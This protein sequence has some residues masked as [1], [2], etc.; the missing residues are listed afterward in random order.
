M[1][2]EV[3]AE[4]LVRSVGAFHRFLEAISF[5]WEGE[6]NVAEVAR[7]CAVGCKT[8]EGFVRIPEDLPPAYWLP[9]FSKLGGLFREEGDPRL[10]TH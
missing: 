1:Q 9:M 7:E 5:S 6:L 2:Q 10:L 4:R 3:Q 8:V